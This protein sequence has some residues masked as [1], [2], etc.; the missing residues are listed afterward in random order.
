MKPEDAAVFRRC[1][2]ED[3]WALNT[4]RQE[5]EG[6]LVRFVVFFGLVFWDADVAFSRFDSKFWCCSSSRSS[7]YEPV[8]S[9]L[10]FSRFPDISSGGG[11]G[12]G[13]G[14]GVDNLGGCGDELEASAAADALTASSSRRFSTTVI[15][16]ILIWLSS[17]MTTC[18]SGVQWRMSS[19]V[20]ALASMSLLL[21]LL[22]RTPFRA[23]KKK[24][25]KA[26]ESGC[27]STAR[28]KTIVLENRG[29][30]EKKG[31]TKLQNN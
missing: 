31:K 17:P 7:L 12:D 26:I 19:F 25:Q 28:R 16:S 13:N 8:P 20:E 21:L 15:G 2:G 27:E 24:P 6:I 11:V 14:N 18:M 9:K 5:E 4:G 29:K 30:E 23:T 10:W 22:Q 1:S 3:W